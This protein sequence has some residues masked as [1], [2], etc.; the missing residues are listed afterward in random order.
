LAAEHLVK[1]KNGGVNKSATA[2]VVQ[3]RLHE[4]NGLH[5]IDAKLLRQAGWSLANRDNPVEDEA[6]RSRIVGVLREK[7]GTPRKKV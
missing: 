2:K 5:E 1:R 7:Y 4:D 6:E 3:K